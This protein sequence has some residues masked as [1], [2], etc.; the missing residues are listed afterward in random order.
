[1]FADEFP[2]A[3]FV[4]VHRDPFRITIS[5]ATIAEGIYQ[6]FIRQQPGPL[7]EDGLHDKI[8]LKR[9]KVIF[10][11]L[12][13]FMKAEP[14]RVA[15]VQYLDL[16]SD[17]VAATRSAFNY[18]AMDLSENFEQGIRAFLEQQRSGKRVAPPKKY[19]NFGYD[20]EAVWANPSVA[21]YCKFFG[22]KQ[23]RTRLIDTKT[24][25]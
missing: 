20:A 21:D 14:Q 18:F 8:I 9:L 3:N 11:A 12:V 15:N 24:G 16:M 7:H 17:A 23:E 1:M 13:K 22:V 6:P 5:A 2:E 10:R 25:L 4:L 19:D